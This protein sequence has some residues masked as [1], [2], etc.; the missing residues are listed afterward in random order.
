MRPPNSW[1]ISNKIIHLP[2]SWNDIPKLVWLGLDAQKNWTIREGYESIDTIKKIQSYDD[3][4]KV[5]PI[6]Q[7]LPEGKNELSIK[8]RKDQ[9]LLSAYI[10]NIKDPGFLELKAQLEKAVLSKSQWSLDGTG[11]STEESK[12]G[13]NTWIT[14]SNS[15]TIIIRKES[16]PQGSKDIR[17]YRQYTRSENEELILYEKMRQYW[18]PEM[19]SLEKEIFELRKELYGTK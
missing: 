19:I 2:D 5:N 7:Y 9:L 16:S 11:V 15:G 8:L 1:S 6:F 18:T 4:V 12:N 13:T 14:K 17:E 3:L 10:R